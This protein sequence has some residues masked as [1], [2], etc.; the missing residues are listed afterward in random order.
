MP[1]KKALVSEYLENISRDALRDYQD[2]I[3]NYV[4]GRQGIYALY[5]K[6][7]L[8][9][10]GLASNLPLRLRQHLRGRHSQLWDRF[11]VYL[12]IGDSH[13]KELES[14]I[15]RIVQPQGNKQSGKFAKA[16][17]LKRRF[18]AEI[19]DKQKEERVRLIGDE[20]KPK[21][22]RKARVLHRTKKLKR[23][24]VLAP[25]VKRRMT[26]KARHK[27]KVI[28]AIVR[29]DGSINYGGKIYASPSAAGAAA[30]KWKSCAGWHFWKYE[31]AP[32]DWVALDEL[33]K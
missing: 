15:L 22:T 2:I 30:G 16:R 31:R 10:V 4:K 29:G 25:Y 3:R 17:N 32:G 7:K 6:G 27:G 23:K 13:L 9:Y 28:S 24:C 14:L 12:T 26:I 11:S 19:R 5:R 20:S 1:G 18:A 21:P 8:Y 33:R